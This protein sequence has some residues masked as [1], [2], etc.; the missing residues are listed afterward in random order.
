MNPIPS[1]R[2]AG[3]N[4]AIPSTIWLAPATAEQ[5]ATAATPADADAVLPNWAL[6]RIRTEFTH[7]P[8]HQAPAPLLHMAIPGTGDGMDART[9][10]AHPDTNPP[11][12][13]GPPVLLA[14]LHDATRTLHK[15]GDNSGRGVEGLA[16]FFHRAYRLLRTGGLLLTA[17]RQAHRDDG[18][19]LDPC[20]QL[21]ASARAAGFVYRQHI[22]LVHATA[23]GSRLHPTPD[24]PA[25]PSGP[26]WRHRPVHSDLLLFTTA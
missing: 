23:S 22:L 17:S 6:R 18:E 5:P 1:S 25:E 13:S 7:R 12:V 2:P 24:A 20:G 10:H 16:G 21:I 26:F 3:A 14:E 19:L 11:K 9:R 4:I 15:P 8:G